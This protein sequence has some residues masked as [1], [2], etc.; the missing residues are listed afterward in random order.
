MHSEGRGTT[1]P[2]EVVGAPGIESERF[3]REMNTKVQGL[4]DGEIETETF[5]YTVVDDDGDEDVATLTITIN[6]RVAWSPS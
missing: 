2:V 6:G 1:R 4:D 3:A 5:T